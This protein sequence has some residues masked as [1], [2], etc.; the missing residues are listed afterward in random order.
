MTTQDAIRTR[1]DLRGIVQGVGFRPFV[2]RLA[3]QMG[4]SGFVANTREGLLIEAEGAP[5]SIRQLIERLHQ[6]RPANSVIDYI[7]VHETATTG[8]AAFSILQ[9]T[10]EGAAPG[11][12]SPDIATCT[13][14]L[15]ELFD[16]NNR[17]YLYPFIT[18][19]ECGPRYSIIE[20]LPFDRERTSM[21]RFSLCVACQDEYTNP[22]DRRFHAETIS[23]PA[24]GPCL[25]L[26][27]AKGVHIN[28][29][30]DAVADVTAALKQGKII[31]IKGVGGFHLATNAADAKSV[32]ELRRR[33]HRPEK[34]FATM[35]RDIK[36]IKDACEVSQEETDLLR[37]RERPIVLVRAKGGAVAS[38]VANN[39]RWLGVML[40]HAPLHHLILEQI[41]F[42]IIM[43]SGN[44]SDEPIIFENSDAFGNL[45]A[46]AD[47][48]LVHD[49]DIIR[50]LD[51]SVV[52]ISCNEPS[53]IRLGRGYA[54]MELQISGMA[55]G[56]LGVG[57]QLKNA[58][59]MSNGNRMVLS[60]Y[61][62]DLGSAAARA[63]HGAI[64]SDMTSLMDTTPQIFAT[65]FHPDFSSS[66]MVA[67]E[68]TL[69]VQHHLAHIHACIVDNDIKTPILGVAWDGAGLGTD[70]S[71]WGGEF[72]EVDGRSWRRV[73]R[74]RSFPLPGAERAMRE[75]RRA[76][77]GLLY[78][79]FGESAFGLHHLPP[80][81]SFSGHELD[82]LKKMVGS[83]INSPLS[84]SVG[85]LFDAFASLTG[86]RQISSFEG[87]AAMLLECSASDT[88][89]DHIYRFDILDDAEPMLIVDWRGVL[90]EALDDIATGIDAAIIGLRFHKGLAHSIAGVAQRLGWRE[91][92][93]TGGCFQNV[94][95][96][97][98]AVRMLGDVGIRSIRH[99]R[100]PPNDGGLAVGQVAWAV[101]LQEESL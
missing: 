75:P 10:K 87:Q 62:G 31:A 13:T 78:A 66:M 1:I 80:I 33:K 70:G 24:C 95:L 15:N 63:R 55:E 58:V 79:A 64:I 3:K 40:P 84:S 52:R 56:V 73:A 34:P 51:D 14:C 97:E 16:P 38:N 74:F 28:S 37:S 72:I 86:I 35:F 61:I 60:Q 45:G 67:S 39:I 36:S 12:I 59:A 7:R 26:F 22:D 43:T 32:D 82:V 11:R 77:I 53:L 94:L 92:A 65:D 49:R 20:S 46:V 90:E 5:E 54:P 6:D 42:P 96:T 23:C 27:D 25:R 17:R 88:I 2:A 68:T 41:E 19:A 71:L 50:P 21:R 47:L 100:V 48:L 81:E 8:D 91:L 85:R 101:K 69:P 57:G 29:G 76:A 98:L 89:D 30:E 83:G 99:R 18:C 4:V 93:L 44:V 9:S